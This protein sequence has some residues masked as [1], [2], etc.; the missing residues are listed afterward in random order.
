MVFCALWMYKIYLISTGGNFHTRFSSP[1]EIF[2]N[3]FYVDDWLL[4]F[5]HLC[6]IS[7]LNFF[8]VLERRE[9]K[10]CFFHVLYLLLPISSSLLLPC[11]NE[12]FFFFIRIDCRCQCTLYRKADLRSFLLSKI[13]G[14]KV[15]FGFCNENHARA[16]RRWISNKFM[17]ACRSV[18]SPQKSSWLKLK[19]K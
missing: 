4:L 15:S 12:V 13:S 11:N 7:F 8:W 18:L 17:Q 1:K 19:L 2:K 3:E 10:S 5:F 16:L 6:I 14:N 9:A